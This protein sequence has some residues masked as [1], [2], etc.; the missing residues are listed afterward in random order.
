MLAMLLVGAACGGASSNSGPTGPAAPSTPATPTVPAAVTPLRVLAE[1]RRLHIGVGT[2]IGSY[3]NRTDAAGAQYMAVLG[4]EFNVVTPENDLKFSAVRPTRGTFRFARPDSMLEF[5]TANG[6]RMRGHTLVWH[7]QLST[8]LTSGSWTQAEGVALLDEHISTVVGHYKGKIAAWDVVNEAFDD[9]GAPRATFWSTLIGPS[10]IAQAFRT[11]AT[12]D[13]GAK[14]FY[15]D[16]NIETIGAK[17]NAVLA[18]LTELKAGGVPVHGVGMQ[19]HFVAGQT[20]SRDALVANMNRFAALGLAIQIT[21]LDIRVQTPAS[22]AALQT[23]AQDYAN[24]V[25]ACLDVPACDMV[26]T[27]GFTDLS[28]WVPSTFA[29]QGA[30][31]LFDESFQPKPAYTSINALLAAS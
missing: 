3:F 26:V 8:W 18:M 13:P 25:R 28:S 10:Y 7:N 23:Q 30:A 14:L 4:R 31:L 21:E 17:S 22:A 29:G 27:W 5:A 24:V 15:N 16:Y 9:A 2:A 12:A 11:A 20:P 1:T 6:M 19:A